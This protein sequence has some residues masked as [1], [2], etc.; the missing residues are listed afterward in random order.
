MH[1]QSQFAGTTLQQLVPH[2]QPARVEMMLRASV[3]LPAQ[4]TLKWVSPGRDFLD[5][6]ED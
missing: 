1:L 6:Y 2:A 5:R 3:L 4:K